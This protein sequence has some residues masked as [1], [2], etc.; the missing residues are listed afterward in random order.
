M[1]L[2]ASGNKL[3]FLKQL[4]FLYYSGTFFCMVENVPCPGTWLHGW[5]LFCCKFAYIKCGIS[6]AFLHARK[7][8]SCHLAEGRGAVLLSI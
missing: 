6:R 4:D 3:G 8:I 5:A 1:R 2:D 7:L